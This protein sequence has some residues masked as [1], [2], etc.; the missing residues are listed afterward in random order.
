MRQRAHEKGIEGSSKMDEKQLRDAMKR[1]DRGAD[2]MMAKQQAKG[3][4]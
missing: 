3:N 1:M 4:R 2:P